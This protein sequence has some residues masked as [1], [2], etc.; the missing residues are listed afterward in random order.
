MF[1]KVVISCGHCETETELS[2]RHSE[3]TDSVYLLSEVFADD[4]TLIDGIQAMKPVCGGCKAPF[5]LAV[6]ETGIAA[7]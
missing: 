7:Q 2:V 4:N 3:A 1:D 6:D 5:S